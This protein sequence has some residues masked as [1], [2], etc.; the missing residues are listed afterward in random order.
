M[1]VLT[2]APAR[3]GIPDEEWQ[4]RC[5]LAALY[6]LLAHF[7]MTD[8]IYTHL[9]A[10]IPGPEHH[11]LINRYGTFFHEMRASDLV[12][13]DLDGKIVDPV[14]RESRRVNA[15][16][17]VIHSAI[18]MARPDLLSVIHTHTAAGIGVSAQ[19]EGLLPISQH[20]L[21]FYDRLGYHNYEG[22][23]FDRAERARLIRDL[24][25]HKAMILRN[26]GLLVGGRS[27]SDTFDQ[28]YFLERAC[29]A[30]VAA[31]AGGQE[32][33]LPPKKVRRHTASQFSD[34][35]DSDLIELAWQASLRLIERD[36]PDYRS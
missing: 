2:R 20:A 33:V 8:L 23:A 9:S 31:L 35:S 21:K 36:Q 28:I 15:A 25:P 26:H 11:F 10:R 7:R 29:Q 24:G 3:A 27:I 13:I 5:D 12:K 4:I 6:R 14:E 16:G 17:F 22:I 1:N 19:K 34:E 18:Y 32:L 30:Q